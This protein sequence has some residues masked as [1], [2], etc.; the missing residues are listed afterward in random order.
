MNDIL[1]NDPPA[2]FMQKNNGTYADVWNELGIEWNGT[3]RGLSIGD[4]DN[5]GDADFIVMNYSSAPKVYRNDTNKKALKIYISPTCSL[6]AG[7]TL[8]VQGQDGKILTTFPSHSFLGAHA[9]ELATA[10]NKDTYIELVYRGQVVFSETL[11]DLEK[12]RVLIPCSQML[13]Q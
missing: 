5:D 13:K 4:L 6:L 8:L 12:T 2:L 7:S 11:I 9:P 3:S 10:M 1:V